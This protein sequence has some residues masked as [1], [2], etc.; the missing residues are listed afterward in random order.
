MNARLMMMLRDY[1]SGEKSFER[2]QDVV[3]DLTL[4]G[5]TAD[6]ETMSLAD[7]VDLRIA[8]YTGGYISEDELKKLI[9]DAISTNPTYVLSADQHARMA[10]L[11]RFQSSAPTQRRTMALG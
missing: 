7:L 1:V 4:G 6:A 5:A 9:A 8:E 11:E 10:R 2:M 3:L